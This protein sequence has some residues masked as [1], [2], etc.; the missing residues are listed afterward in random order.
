MNARHLAAVLLALVGVGCSSTPPPRW[1]E[2]GAPLLVSAARWERPRGGPIEISPDG[3]VTRDG[4]PYLYVDRAGRVADRRNEPVAILLP[5]GFVAG[6]DDRLLGRVGVAN[7]SPP[8]RASAW[9]SVQPD[10]RVVY[11]DDDGDRSDAGVWQG[12]AGPA[13]RT[14]TLVTHIVRMERYRAY[15]D[16]PGPRFGVGV[17]I[18]VG[19]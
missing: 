14:C 5:D 7:A 2:G 4:K 6:T 18:G 19:F 12:C 1:Q 10:G 8:H 9:L 13:L 16:G 15:R 11:F 17:G 3:H